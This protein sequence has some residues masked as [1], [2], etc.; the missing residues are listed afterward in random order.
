MISSSKPNRV[1]VILSLLG[2]LL[3]LSGDFIIPGFYVSGFYRGMVEPSPVQ[4][5]LL[6]LLLPALTTLGLA[7]RGKPPRGAAVLNGMLCALG[8]LLQILAIV[9]VGAFDDSGAPLLPLLAPPVLGLVG[10]LISVV[11]AFFT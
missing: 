7:Y 5:I 11:G 9:F 8:V 6:V 10:Y 4:V 2:A 3:I 1:G